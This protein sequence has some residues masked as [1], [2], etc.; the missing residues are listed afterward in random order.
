MTTTLTPAYERAPS[1]ELRRLLSPEGFL[2][3]LLGLTS[4]RVNGLELDVHL[5][6]NDEVQVY[7]G[8]TR[9]LN[10]RRNRNGTVGVSAHQTYSKQGCAKAVLRRWNIGEADRFRKSLDAYIRCVKIA[11][12]HTCKRGSRPVHVVACY[13]SLGS[14]RQRGRPEL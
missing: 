14:V 3:P 2:E 12:R 13:A 10:V 5:R 9:I 7:C 8:L 1:E 6:V 4:R 11:K